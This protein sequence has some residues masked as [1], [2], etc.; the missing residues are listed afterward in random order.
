MYGDTSYR[1]LKYRETSEELHESINN[2]KDGLEHWGECSTEN[3]HWLSLHDASPDAIRY[4]FELVKCKH[5][6]SYR[7]LK[8]MKMDF[9]EFHY[10]GKAYKTFHEY[11]G[12]EYD[13]HCRKFI[14]WE[15]SYVSG[16]ID[17]AWEDA[18]LS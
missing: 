9:A 17:L 15:R 1:K 3:T 2:T 18:F 6:N 11:K 7:L 4:H 5:I 8:A 16:K 12:K 13:F 10:G 14:E